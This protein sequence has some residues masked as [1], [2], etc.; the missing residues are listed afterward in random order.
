VSFLTGQRVTDRDVEMGIQRSVR[1]IVKRLSNGEI[2]PPDA[3][4]QLV[5]LIVKVVNTMTRRFGREGA[6][7]LLA[8][9]ALV[10][11][12]IASLKASSTP[13]FI[14]YSLTTAFI[15]SDAIKALHKIQ[16]YQSDTR[17]SSR[18]G[19]E[20]EPQQSERER[21]ESGHKVV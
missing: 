16:T 1:L 21:P 3:N 11:E 7:E 6:H 12:R 8:D 20:H 15:Q 14:D 5:D 4:R 9:V 17:R 2:D 13:G 18:E 10:L 19:V